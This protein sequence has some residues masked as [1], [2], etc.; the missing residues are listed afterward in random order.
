[1]ELPY[2]KIQLSANMHRGPVTNTSLSKAGWDRRYCSGFSVG[3]PIEKPENSWNFSDWESV[4][5]NH[6]WDFTLESS[7]WGL[8]IRNAWKVASGHIEE[9]RWGHCWWQ[10]GCQMPTLGKNDH[11]ILQAMKTQT[12]VL[13]S[14]V[15]DICCLFFGRH[16]FSLRTWN[17]VYEIWGQKELS[18]ITLFW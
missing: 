18:L 10:L 8:Y 16:G 17:S 1:M 15:N 7:S 11:P 4:W 5:I 9:Y 6:N 14:Y 12:P 13:D 2:L 3:C